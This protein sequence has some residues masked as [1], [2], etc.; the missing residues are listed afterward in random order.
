M[1]AIGRDD[2]RA[3]HGEQRAVRELV[4]RGVERDGDE[5]A[6]NEPQQVEVE[7][8]R[9]LAGLALG[10]LVRDG[11]EDG[12]RR[13]V[14]HGGAEAA[15]QPGAG[16]VVGEDGQIDDVLDDREAGADGE[17]GDDRVE[18]VADAVEAEE[19]D[20]DRAP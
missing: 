9:G 18:L 3:E 17:A 4:E 13:P 1:I 14:H 5:I 15:H 12:E 8:A 16:A 20:D 7:V 6:G 10:E 2:D 11:G 19:Q